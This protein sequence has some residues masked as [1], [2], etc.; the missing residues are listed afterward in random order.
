MD[1]AQN[2]KLAWAAFGLLFLF[3]AH[4]FQH[5]LGGYGLQIAFN[6]TVWVVALLLGTIGVFSAVNR[7]VWRLP[8][9]WLAYVLLFI[10]LFLPLAWS[11]QT[12]EYAIGRFFG[13]LG[14]LFFFVAL[15]QCFDAKR[16]ERT[17]L[18]ILLC[19]VGIEALLGALQLFGWQWLPIGRITGDAIRPQ[20]IFQ[21]PNVF[22]SYLAM[23]IAAGLW[24]LIKHPL[25]AAKPWQK[26]MWLGVIYLTL[27]LCAF[28]LYV[29]L[30]RTGILAL[31]GVLLL[32][33]WAPKGENRRALFTALAFI[34]IG[35]LAGMVFAELSAPIRSDSGMLLSSNGRMNIWRIS[36]TLFLEHPFTG[37]GLGGFEAAY[38]QQ[39]AVTFAQSGVLAAGNVDHPHNELLF[40]AVE[41][42]C[43]PLFALL[44]FVGYFIWRLAR[45]GRS[46]LS[47]GALLLPFALHSLTEYPF[48]HSATHWF[49]FLFLLFLAE[50]RMAQVHEREVKLP[51]VFKSLSAIG[52]LVGSLFMVTNLH[53][54]YKLVEVARANKVAKDGDSPLAPL[55]DIV[56]PIVFQNHIEH[57]AMYARLQ[58]AL[59][60]HD[61]KTLQ[62]FIQWGWQFSEHVVRADTF[63]YML[64][65]AQALGDKQQ[66][67]AI[68]KRAKWLYPNNP[69]FDLSASGAAAPR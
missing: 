38:A 19:S 2:N 33:L 65:A 17:L 11:Q 59:K 6:N 1:N 62:T 5:N 61:T 14:G 36:G 64:E 20:G 68:R 51:Y 41:G 57:I 55:L 50:S 21:Q 18:F 48:Y 28:G 56:N 24:L 9:S 35:E 25:P 10:A 40:W 13:V 53:A 47:Y 45:L 3:A 44:A 34:V 29:T 26:P 27:G 67:E 37:V 42:G 16:D 32:L 31:V 39:R 15:F 49:A 4:Y 8:S 30:S 23:G 43:L 52:L 63:I 60:S 69:S 46:G 58:L 7:G 22:S 54:I 66:E 12:G